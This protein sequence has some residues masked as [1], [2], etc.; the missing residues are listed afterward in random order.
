MCFFA[1]SFL[2]PLSCSFS[3]IPLLF[4]TFTKVALFFSPPTLFNFFFLY[5]WYDCLG[6]QYFLDSLN[7]SEY[8]TEYFLFLCLGVLKFCSIER[9]WTYWNYNFFFNCCHYSLFL[10]N[11]ISYYYQTKQPTFICWTNTQ[12]MPR[13]IK[14]C[15]LQLKLKLDI[16]SK[17][18]YICSV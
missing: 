3:L 2:C 1:L 18:L 14:M 10:L 15:C 6:Q 16:E 11:F 7:I 12:K 8:S 17:T 4:Q 13:C 9:I 5:S